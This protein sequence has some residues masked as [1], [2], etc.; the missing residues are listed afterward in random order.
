M[1]RVSF[2]KFV[3]QLPDR[4]LKIK[5]KLWDVMLFFYDHARFAKTKQGGRRCAAY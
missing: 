2:A 1:F 5:S 4:R 3:K